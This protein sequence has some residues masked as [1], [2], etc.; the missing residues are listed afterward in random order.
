MTMSPLFQS[1]GKRKGSAEEIST[2]DPSNRYKPLPV[3]RVFQLEEIN[4]SRTNSEAHLFA[5]MNLEREVSQI[6]GKTNIPVNATLCLRFLIQA[7][8]VSLLSGLV[9]REIEIEEESNVD[10]SKLEE[11]MS[12]LQRLREENFHLKEEL[13]SLRHYLGTMNRPGRAS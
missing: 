4:L 8:E 3:R 7:K 13:N 9:G 10:T 1:R 12:E 6:P 2:L 11:A 5:E